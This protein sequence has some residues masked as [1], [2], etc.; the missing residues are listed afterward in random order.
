[1]SFQY[2]QPFM[3]LSG[4]VQT[5]NPPAVANEFDSMYES[6]NPLTTVNKQHFVEWFSGKQLPSYWTLTA[7]S[8]AME[9][10]VDGGYKITSPAS[11]FAHAG[12]TFNLKRQ[13]SPTAS[14]IIGVIR[15]EDT[16]TEMYFGEVK[17]DELNLVTSNEYSLYSN[18]SNV[19]NTFLRTSGNG[20]SNNDTSTSIANSTNTEVVKIEGK[21][22]SVECTVNGTLEATSTT[23]LPTSKLQAGFESR[24]RNNVAVDCYITYLEIYNT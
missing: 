16:D 19:T 6:F 20:S 17:T 1:M 5:T 3:G 24:A 14:V 23:N 7:G 9:D 18:Q 13:Y 12:I 21:S 4:G 8:G 22:S 10:S 2:I 15:R 11:Q